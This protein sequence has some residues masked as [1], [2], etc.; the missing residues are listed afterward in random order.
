MLSIVRTPRSHGSKTDIGGVS[1]SGAYRPTNAAITRFPTSDAAT[2]APQVSNGTA[3]A[4]SEGHIPWPRR[5]AS[6]LPNT[7]HRSVLHHPKWTRA[8]LNVPLTQNAPKHTDTRYPLPDF[9][10]QNT[11]KFARTSRGV[12]HRVGHGS[13]AEKRQSLHASFPSGTLN[14]ATQHSYT[15]STRPH[16]ISMCTRHRVSESRVE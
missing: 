16:A 13:H 4:C 6:T 7:R 1:T 5:E 11:C 14:R 12:N 9:Y 15:G 10:L 2:A 3:L 8:F